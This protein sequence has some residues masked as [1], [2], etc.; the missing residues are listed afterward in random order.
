ME[1]LAFSF[2]FGRVSLSYFFVPSLSWLGK[3]IKVDE[4]MARATV[5]AAGGPWMTVPNVFVTPPYR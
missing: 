3:T 5:H 2:Q 4:K 1:A